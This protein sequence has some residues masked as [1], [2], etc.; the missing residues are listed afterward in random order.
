MVEIYVNYVSGNDCN[1]GNKDFPLK[2]MEKAIE[3]A[4]SSE[5]A[6]IHI[7]GKYFSDKTV[8]IS[9][10]KQQLILKGEDA[11]IEGGIEVDSFEEYN[12]KICRA[13][14]GK[15]RVVRQ[16]FVGSERRKRATFG[17]NWLYTRDW[18]NPMDD[19]YVDGPIK[20]KCKKNKNL[21]SVLRY[22]AISKEKELHRL[23]NAD[24]CGC[25]MLLLKD[26]VIDYI[27]VKGIHFDGEDS[28]LELEDRTGKLLYETQWP[29]K[30]Y[31]Q[32]FRLEGCLCFLDKEGEW[33]YEKESGYLYY[34][35]KRDENLNT[36][37]G[38]IPGDC[39]CLLKIS[40]CTGEIKLENLVFE[41]CNWNFPD[42]YGIC[43][44]QAFS[45]RKFEKNQIVFEQSGAALKIE[46][47]NNITV[48]RC[49]FK[50]CSASAIA[51]RYGCEH[52]V[53]RSCVFYDLSGS[54]VYIGT[55]SLADADLCRFIT[56]S[57]NYIYKI[58]R[59]YGGAV[60]IAMKF[61][62]HVEIS[63]NTIEDT[64]YTGISSG[65]HWTVKKTQ[66]GNVH[67]VGNRL[68]NVANKL[69]DGGAI[70][71]LSRQDGAV[72]EE[73]YLSGIYKSKYVESPSVLHPIYLDEGSSY[74]LVQNNFIDD[75]DSSFSKLLDK[76]SDEYL[77]ECPNYNINNR[78]GNTNITKNAFTE[79]EEI[80]K[81][82][83]VRLSDVRMVMANFSG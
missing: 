39:E 50:K 3:K 71:T 4:N 14:I 82:S 13:F 12:G 54:A 37:K 79:N 29:P 2:H 28:Y 70:Y 81:L 27:K 15:N 30:R 6:L 49:M 73:N 62:N 20:Q 75:F 83:G 31:R 69:C 33:C 76:D 61:G 66:L 11:V 52:I 60:A 56:V 7:Q 40:D 55:E 25:E 36:L 46:R 5:G 38:C 80:K 68:I 32:S 1:T 8:Q 58:G 16:F 10:I 18:Y 19:I 45:P 35:L 17:E 34:Y 65:W 43:D 26:W 23:K 74:I 21:S 57:D 64:P 47:S 44:L 48:E 9:G 24:L 41:Y 53:V 59:D 42:E 51:I 72:I 78:I 77:S 67:I 63:H 22:A